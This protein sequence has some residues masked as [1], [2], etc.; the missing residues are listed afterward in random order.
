MREVEPFDPERSMFV[1]DS[2]PVLRAARD[3]GIRWIYAVRQ[4]DSSGA[5]RVHD[6]FLLSI[7]S[8]TCR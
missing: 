2:P 1:D 8:R 5:P 7:P 3:A 4:P 6:E